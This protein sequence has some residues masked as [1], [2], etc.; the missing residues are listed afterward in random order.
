MRGRD[1]LGVVH[2]VGAGPGAADLITMRGHRLVMSCDALV[3]DHLVDGELVESSPA[4]IKIYAGKKAGQHVMAQA[5]INDLLVDLATRLGGPQRIVRLKGGD[6][7]V[8]GRGGEE[9]LACVR[10]GIPV[11]VVP[12]VSAGMAAPAMVGVPLTH[13]GMSRGVTF[14]TGH[15]HDGGA[16]DLPWKELVASGFTLVFFMAVATLGR[17]ADQLIKHGMDPTTPAVVVQEATSSSQGRVVADVSHVALEAK[18]RGIRAPAV[19]VVG[20]VVSIANEL[21]VWFASQAATSASF[22]KAISA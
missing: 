14:V 18:Q 19:V 7:F 20:G 4:K 8:F 21:A 11:S 10:H 6:P 2:L 22:G 1:V 12:G 3:Y 5:S 16:L 9:A 13:R 15:T 17:I